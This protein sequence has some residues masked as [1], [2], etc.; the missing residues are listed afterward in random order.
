M[1]GTSQPEPRVHTQDI[2]YQADGARLV[3]FLA[4]DRERPGRRPAVLIGHEGLG[5][6]EHAKTTARR[7]AA[8]G[9][10]AFALDY[11]GEG[12]P[13]PDPGQ[14]RTAIMRWLADPAGIRARAHAG[15]A[16]LLDQAETDPGRVAAIGY[17]FGGTTV[18]ELARDGADLA[19]VAG[20]HS[21]LSTAR[22]DDAA[23]I[24]GK[25][26]VQI[27]AD[28]PIV[29]PEQRAAFEAEMRAGQ[30]DWR[31]IVY[32]G[33]VHSFTN[34]QASDRGLPGLAYDPHAAARSWR[35]MLDLFDEAL[36]PV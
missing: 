31:M 27:G 6:D 23:R 13:L 14:A 20:F 4:V 32:G 17:C 10:A 2:E 29:P 5:L 25:V 9:Y 19:A 11:H 36:G 18:L 30:V 15:L 1:L 33:V 21:G 26:L 3:G 24:K 7:L 34:P 12:R 8:L 16:V 28:D 35:A 22:P